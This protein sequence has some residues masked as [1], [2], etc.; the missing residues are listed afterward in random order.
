MKTR[1]GR[2]ITPASR[3]FRTSQPP[4]TH[5]SP[6]GDTY[7]VKK[8][9]K[10][11]SMNL[12]PIVTRYLLIVRGT[13]QIVSADVADSSQ[14]T[15][16]SPFEYDKDRWNYEKDENTS[17]GSVSG[18]DLQKVKSCSDAV[19]SS[20]AYSDEIDVE[21][22]E[23]N[24]QSCSSYEG[25]LVI[26]MESAQFDEDELFE[27]SRMN[28]YEEPCTIQQQDSFEDEVYDVI[29]NEDDRTK[30]ETSTTSASTTIT[31]S[32]TKKAEFHNDL[33]MRISML[34]QETDK[35]KLISTTN[36]NADIANTSS[37]TSAFDK[38]VKVKYANK[39]DNLSLNQIRPPYMVKIPP[40]VLSDAAALAS[41]HTTLNRSY[42]GIK[43]RIGSSNRSIEIKQEPSETGEEGSTYGD[44]DIV[45]MKSETT[46]LNG[47]FQTEEE[48]SQSSEET[49][50][51][52]EPIYDEDPESSLYEA[53]RE[54]EIFMYDSNGNKLYKC[55]ICNK[56]FTTFAAF[57]SHNSAHAKNKNKC[58]Y[59]G[60]LF[61]RS[62]LLKGH[63]RTHTGERPYPCQYP[64]CHKAFADKS[65]LRSHMLIHTV[66]TK[67]FQCAKCGRAFAQKR[68]L[69]KHRLEVCR[70]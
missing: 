52:E 1:S 51:K 33:K 28:D 4:S 62:W 27:I 3:L 10:Y 59:C 18:H 20:S 50:I 44:V 6:S 7:K 57:K 68:Y 14:I 41:M 48:Q 61:S 66:T 67:N 2:M 60:K 45:D 42:T 37:Y 31:S 29:S 24:E 38:L 39:K 13:N 64:G 19:S 46:T 17:L 56:I 47:E 36:G 49:T 12:L 65:N 9:V 30:L 55:T 23:D 25:A 22:V 15:E 69:H 70:Y 21:H 32:E 43:I 5:C 34:Q 35:L 8:I 53:I 63:M 40:S 54:T 16:D 11:K 26:D 58:L